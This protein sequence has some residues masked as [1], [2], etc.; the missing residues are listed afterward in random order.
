MTLIDELATKKD[1]SIVKEEMKAEI[2][3]IVKQ[4]EARGKKPIAVLMDFN[5]ISQ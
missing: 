1:F 5:S 2:H 3:M 4:I